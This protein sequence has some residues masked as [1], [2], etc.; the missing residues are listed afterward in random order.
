MNGIRKAGDENVSGAIGAMLCLILIN[1]T[2]YYLRIIFIATTF[3]FIILSMSPAD[4][5]IR[6][7][8]SYASSA[9]MWFQASQQERCGFYNA[10]WH[11]NYDVHYNWCRGATIHQ[12]AIEYNSRVAELRDCRQRR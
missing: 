3:S 2:E 5:N 11:G 10:R 4:A 9:V 7:C 8:R 1:T 12:R 6:N